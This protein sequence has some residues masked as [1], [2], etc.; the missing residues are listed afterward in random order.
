LTAVGHFE[1]IGRKGR[2]VF[3]AK[4]AMKT[5]L[6]FAFIKAMFFICRY[7]WRGRREESGFDNVGRLSFFGATD[8]DGV[9]LIDY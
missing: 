6:P 7:L 1:L 9:C 2:I 3:V 8:G 5:F 4:P